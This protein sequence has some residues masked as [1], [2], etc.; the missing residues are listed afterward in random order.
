M[1]FRG[2]PEPNR[3]SNLGKPVIAARYGPRAIS[4]WRVARPACKHGADAT[5]TSALADRPRYGRGGDA[6]GIVAAQAATR[7]GHYGCR[8]ARALAR[9]PVGVGQRRPGSAFARSFKAAFGVPPHRYLLTRR[10]ERAQSLL[11]DTDLPVIA[12]AFQAGWGSL[13]TFGRVFP[14]VTGESPTLFRTR[15]KR[16]AHRLEPV[17]PCFVS[18]AHR[19]D[20][21]IAVSEQRRRQEGRSE[22]ADRRRLP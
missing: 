3:I 15:E 7:Q 16:V 1:S 22:A 21:T 5:E 8:L 6:G 17:P 4:G 14:D 18:A 19:P 13:G 11:R 20:L 10:I 12:I 9:A 2:S